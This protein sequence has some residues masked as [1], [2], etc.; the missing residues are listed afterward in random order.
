MGPDVCSIP[1]LSPTAHPE[2]LHATP[3]RAWRP[4]ADGWRPLFWLG[5]GFALGLLVSLGSNYL[6]RGNPFDYA[7]GQGFT[8]ELLP[9]LVAH[10]LS[11]GLASSGTSRLPWRCRFCSTPGLCGLVRTWRLELGTALSDPP[12]PAGRHS[13]RCRSRGTAASVGP[14]RVCGGRPRRRP[15]QPVAPGRGPACGVLGLLGS[16]FAGTPSYWRQFKLGAYQPI[17]L[18]TQTIAD[19]QKASRSPISCGLGSLRPRVA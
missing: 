16:S 8:G 1:G 19:S 7:Y 10:L 13:C 4:I 12:R 2:I 14:P 18:W 6:R 5:V 11:P 15:G 3:A 17:G 9:G